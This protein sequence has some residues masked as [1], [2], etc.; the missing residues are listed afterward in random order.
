MAKDKTPRDAAGTKAANEAMD[1]IIHD[2]NDDNGAAAEAEKQGAENE[3]PEQQ[4][5]GDV[6]LSREEI[7]KLRSEIS[8][9]KQ[10]MDA[11]ILDAQR[12]QAEFNN[13]RKRNASLRTDSIDD[14]MRDVIKGLL[15]VLDN[16]ETAL[17]N[18]DDSSFAK[19]TEQIHKQLIEV[20]TKFGLEEIPAEGVFDPNLHDAVIRDEEGEGESGTITAVLQKGYMVKGKIIR[21]T[22]VKVRV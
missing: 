9:M 11:A 19:G 3:A 18:S 14:G 6:T 17:A 13:Y 22:M 21:H 16:S 2:D 20:L 7:E 10:S 4:D 15:P 1:A 12:I 8:G 5:C